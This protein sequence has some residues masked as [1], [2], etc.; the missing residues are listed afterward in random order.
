MSGSLAGEDHRAPPPVLVRPCGGIR[1]RL[2]RTEQ[3]R[4]LIAGLR[5]H[6]PFFESTDDSVTPRR[7]H[8]QAGSSAQ[9][10]S[11]V[12]VAAIKTRLR[13]MVILMIPWT[14]ISTRAT[15]GIMVE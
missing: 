12:E 10:R 14:A 3:F 7:P 9:R 13:E 6:L 15:G 11:A 4:Q 1:D 8:A 5:G 2:I